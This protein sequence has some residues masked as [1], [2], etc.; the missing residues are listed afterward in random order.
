M[1]LVTEPLREIILFV[2]DME[3]EVRFYR[4]VLG[5]KIAYPSGLADYSEEMWV[6]FSTGD[7]TLALH[8]GSK[9]EPA[10][11]HEIIFK[12]EDV[13]KA[14]KAIM[15]AGIHMEAVRDLEDG[16]PISEGVDP[17]GHRFAIRA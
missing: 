4:D 7:C 9:E 8:G 10:G 2:Q 11:Q 14:R 13:A 5:L 6:A 3:S 17:A 12:V 1:S 16:A 15:D